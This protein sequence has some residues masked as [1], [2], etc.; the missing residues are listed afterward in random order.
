MGVRE[1]LFVVS[2]AFVGM[3]VVAADSYVARAAGSGQD[4]QSALADVRRAV[5]LGAAI[6]LA[7]AFMLASVMSA[8]ITSV[9]RALTRATRRMNEGDLSVRTHLPGGDEFAELGHS[10]D[11]LAGGLETTLRDLRVERDLHRNILEAMHD[12]VVGG[13]SPR[14]RRCS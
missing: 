5:W 12:G 8:R 3:A 10:L 11:R 14:P 7:A 1:K 2:A 9:A 6:A 4:V 13:R